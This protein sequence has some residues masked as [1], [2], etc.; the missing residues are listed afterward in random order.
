[1]IIVTTIET[2]APFN[3]CAT[4]TLQSNKNCSYLPKNGP[5]NYH[6]I[7]TLHNIPP[8]P[9]VQISSLQQAQK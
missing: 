2:K 9:F 8:F 1:M 3:Y 5:S 7:Y 6:A 4:Y